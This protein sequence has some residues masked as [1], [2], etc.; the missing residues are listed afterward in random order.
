V[1]LDDKLPILDDPKHLL[2]LEGL[3]LENELDVVVIDPL[4]LALDVGMASTNIYAM[5]GKLRAVM[6][7]MRETGC[8]LIFNHHF[9]KGNAVV[10]PDLVHMAAAG[11]QEYVRQWI[12]LGRRKQYILIKMP[13]ITSYG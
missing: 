7:L 11:I 9:T 6:E 10:K 4:Y 8:T 13:A 1:V 2:A 12:L 3:I 5:G